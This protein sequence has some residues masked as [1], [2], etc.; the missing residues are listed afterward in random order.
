[1]AAMVTM[2]SVMS[3]RRSR[4]QTFIIELKRRLVSLEAVTLKYT[5]KYISSCIVSKDVRHRTSVAPFVQ[6]SGESHDRE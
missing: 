5:L 4:D 6:R 3:A 2:A 1:M